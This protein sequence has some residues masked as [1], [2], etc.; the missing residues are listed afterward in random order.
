M[1][2]MS[3]SGRLA[4]PY[5]RALFEL[6]REGGEDWQAQLDLLAAIAADAGM[7]ALIGNPRV[8][9]GQLQTLI[10]DVAAKRLSAPGAN[11]VKLLARNG[12]LR[13]L[14]AIARAYAELRAEAQGVI[15]VR[16]TSAAETAPSQRKQFEAALQKKLGRKIELEFAVDPDLL[17]GAVVRAGDSVI[18][19]SVRA[20]LRQL[21]GALSA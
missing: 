16:I 7:A 1:S 6:A 8:S 2:A 20:Q 21:A 4:R 18:D 5:A 15:A 9:A 19:G 12:R 14:P 11:L 10:I 3:E 13:A 17:G